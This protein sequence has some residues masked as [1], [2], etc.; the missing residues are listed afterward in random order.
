MFGR[1]YNLNQ[2]S[3]SRWYDWRIKIFLRKYGESMLI[4][5]YISDLVAHATV[6]EML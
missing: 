2:A 1:I 6:A 3:R 4:T 5:F